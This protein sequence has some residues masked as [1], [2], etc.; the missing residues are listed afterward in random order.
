MMT[1]KEEL[2]MLVI[3]HPEI[4]EPLFELLQQLIG[5]LNLPGSA[6]EEDLS[7]ISSGLLIF[8]SSKCIYKNL[9]T[10]NTQNNHSRCKNG[11]N[12][13]PSYLLNLVLI[14]YMVCYERK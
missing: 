9:R 2:E 4:A 3:Q 11:M 6:G 5:A 12:R 13:S 14:S 8:Q 10:S 7:Y 1:D